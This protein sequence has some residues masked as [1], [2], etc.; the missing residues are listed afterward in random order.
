MANEHFDT[1]VIGTGF[2]GLLCAIHLLEAGVDSICVFEMTGS[3]GGVWSHGG[4][5]AYPGAACDVPAYT[6]LPF[7]DRTGFIPSK[8][9]VSQPEIAG[10]AEMLTDHGGIRDLIRFNRKVVELR[11][12]DPKGDDT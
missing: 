2:S 5:G 7:L 1:V 8:K 3:V 9:Y 11:C 4:V 6:Y 10:Y 12:L